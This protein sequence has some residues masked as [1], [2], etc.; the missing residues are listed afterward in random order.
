[1][2]TVSSVLAPLI[3]GV[4]LSN[5]VQGVPLDS[6]GDF[7]GNFWSLFSA[8]TVA[9]GIATVVLFALHGSIFLELKAHGDLRERARITAQRIAAPAVVVVAVF[10]AWTV[11]VATDNNHKDAFPAAI[12]AAAAVLALAIGGLLA[13]RSPGGKAFTATAIGVALT[14]AT[15]FTSLYPRVL[16]SSP[17]FANSL[18]VQGAASSHYALTVMT[19]VAVI[20]APLILLYQG[21]TY[22]VFRRR[23][24]DPPVNV[25]APDEA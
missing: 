3:W 12:V 10:L 23:L 21:W 7:A 6:S 25:P 14:V 18:T 1:V 8:Y 2:N 22:H 19:V 24:A 9:G 4:A 17:D 15:I 20:M 13:T 16:V 5:L 11:V